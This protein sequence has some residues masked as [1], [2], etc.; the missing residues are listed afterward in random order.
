M[1]V[2]LSPEDKIVATEKIFIYGDYPYLRVDRK[3]ISLHKFIANRMGLFIRQGEVID[4]INGN[5]FDARRENLRILNYSQNNQNR[6]MESKPA[7]G[8]RGV[9]KC[10]CGPRW[11]VYCGTTRVGYFTTPEDGANAYD[12]YIIKFVHRDG[13]TNFEHSETL[14]DEILKSDFE[15]QTAKKFDPEM[16]G[17]YWKEDNRAY[18]VRVHGKNVGRMFKELDEAQKARDD[19]YKKYN[20][21]KE[22]KRLEVPIRV[23]AN[24]QAII[25]LTGKRGVGKFGIV[26]HDVWH[27][28]MK[29]SWNL[30]NTGY[31]QAR[32][33]TK[34]WSLHEYLMKDVDRDK[35]AMVIDH[36]NT[37]KLDN[38]LS[39]LR[40]IS[41]SE[42]AKNLS[43]ET[44]KR[45]SESQR[46]LV[47]PRRENRKHPEDNNLPKY[48][49]S[50]RTDK[51]QGYT[52]QK[53]PILKGKTYTN[54]TLS[55]EEN[56]EKALEYLRTAHS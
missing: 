31:S 43:D 36:I 25:P 18:E 13:Q 52:I 26:D 34:L 12:K 4:H 22:R 45:I 29:S 14:K 19:G 2:L 46:G 42:N 7:S 30:A 20:E 11:Q 48:L 41:R 54:P 49:S 21:E 56:L 6:V 37:N 27:E 35:Q 3:R 38:R 1:E 50:I 10:G 44:R 17:V 15:I 32:I 33:N 40:V 23:N 5:K 47:K 53:H 51:H 16:M 39:N 24:G 28:L 8:F 9:Y 55:M